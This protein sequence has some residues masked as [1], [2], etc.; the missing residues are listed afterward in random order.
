M[1]GARW[2]G[3]GSGGF[4]GR[5]RATLVG[6][7]LVALILATVGVAAAVQLQT[8][9][10]FFKFDTRISPHRLSKTHT[11]P[12]TIRSFGRIFTTDGSPPLAL[13]KVFVKLDRDLSVDTEGL[14]ACKL[15][16][17]QAKDG[18]SALRICRRALVGRGSMETEIA[19][20]GEVPV[21]AHGKVLI[22]NGGTRHGAV[23]LLVHSYLTSPVPAVAVTP[24]S[25][26][27]I[28]RGPYAQLAIATV[29]RVAGGAGAI[30]S[31]NAKI[32]R[33]YTL[34]GKRLSVVSSTC[35]HHRIRSQVKA[36][37]SDGTSV[38]GG[39]VH[40]CSAR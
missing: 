35:D 23:T 5:A 30:V 21:F 4:R 9:S 24:V 18:Q 31:F 11:T 37:F 16:R 13:K 36:I 10:T 22:F 20:P 29:P 27:R 3:N 26:R 33:R 39:L 12:A 7:T 8:G 14:P 19:F 34:R 17:I 32:R 2:R 38:Q 1:F 40:G 28:R 25:I 15:V 6:L